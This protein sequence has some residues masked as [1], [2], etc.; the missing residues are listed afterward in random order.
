MN[1]ILTCCCCNIHETELTFSTSS[2]LHNFLSLNS[3][4]YLFILPA[5]TQ[6]P[7]E[8][9]VP[10]PPVSEP[11][12]QTVPDAGLQAGRLSRPGPPRLAPPYPGP[13]AGRRAHHE[14]R[15]HVLGQRRQQPQQPRDPPQHEQPRRRSELDVFL[16]LLL[17]LLKRVGENEM[18]E[19][20][21][22]RGSRARGSE[23]ESGGK[24]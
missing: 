18:R 15:T 20:K 19:I 13:A 24:G 5:G 23:I 14:E 2:D 22:E 6:P 16:L 7:G 1:H 4:L 17:L 11:A 12:G 10:P 9:Q 8:L 21:R 3:V